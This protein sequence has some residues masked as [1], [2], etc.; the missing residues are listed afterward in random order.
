MICHTVDIQRRLI[1]LCHRRCMMIVTPSPPL[2]PSLLNSFKTLLP[3]II[4]H[5]C[6]QLHRIAVAAHRW[7]LQG[8]FFYR[9]AGQV[10]PLAA[11][12]VMVMCNV[13]LI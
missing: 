7:V 8:R 6:I 4:F 2:L 11:Q 1:L 9:Q 10:A 12:L 5:H 3:P 13:E